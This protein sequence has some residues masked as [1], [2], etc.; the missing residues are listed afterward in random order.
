MASKKSLEAGDVIIEKLELVDLSG[1]KRPYNLLE[2]FQTINIFESIKSPVITGLM[3]VVDGINLRE[4]YPIIADKC[5]IVFQFKNDPNLPSRTFDLLISEINNIQPEQNGQYTKYDLVLC[6]K[7]ILDNSKQMFTTS[8][9]QKR[10]DEYIKFIMTD[11]ISTNKNVVLYSGGNT[12][13]VQ[14]L[15][16][17]QMKPFQSIDYLRR[18]AVSIK[19]KSSSYCFFENK[20]GFVFAPIEF[21]FEREDGKLKDAEFFFDTD[22]RQNAKN[23]TIRNILAY[24][25]LTQQS[26][27]KMVQEGALKNV[28]TSLDL[29]TRSYQTTTF[30]LKKEFQNFKFP[31]K[32]SNINT[33]NFEN[34][35]GNS[36]AITNYTINTSKN[37]DDYLV[38]KIGFNKAFVELLTQN[39]LRIMTWGDS[40]L[41]AGYRIQC[42]VPSIDGQTKPKGKKT[43]ELSSFVSGEYLISSIRHMF[44]KLQAKHRYLN[45][46][47]LIKGTYGETRRG[48]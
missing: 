6:S 45:S 27:A 10:I 12:K 18:R 26:T 7:E 22:V 36:P 39:I 15:D 9:R 28:T 31:G 21:L 41:S 16:L 19:Y 14:D 25:H 47:E 43:N 2:Q 44:H 48:A 30:D 24:N 13:G 5:K 35:Y 38:D 40:V 20:A 34:E 3:Q 29:R 23:V 32:T 17:I 37:P 1:K 8:M 4:T 33:A 11:V 42:Q 46:M